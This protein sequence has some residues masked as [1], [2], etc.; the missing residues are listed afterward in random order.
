MPDFIRNF[1]GIHGAPRRAFRHAAL[2]GFAALTPSYAGYF[3]P[4]IP[5]KA[6][7]QK[8]VRIGSCV[9]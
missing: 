1:L 5:A 9:Q 6:G 8:S 7:I 2:L 4:V 3:Y